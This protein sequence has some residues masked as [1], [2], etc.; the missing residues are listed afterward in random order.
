LTKQVF[1]GFP[2]P[3]SELAWQVGWRRQHSSRLSRLR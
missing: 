2:F 3:L 1:S